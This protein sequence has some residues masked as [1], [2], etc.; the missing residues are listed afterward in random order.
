MGISLLFRRVFLL[1]RNPLSFLLVPWRLNF[2][3]F[4]RRNDLSGKQN[5]SAGGQNTSAGKRNTS[6]GRRNEPTGG[7]NKSAGKRNTSAGR[8][9]ESVGEQN[10]SAGRQNTSAGGRNEPAGGQNTSAGRRNEPAGR[11][12]RSAKAAAGS[13]SASAPETAKTAKK[14]TGRPCPGKG[15][16]PSLPASRDCFIRLCNTGSLL[17][18]SCATRIT[19]FSRFS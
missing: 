12:N 11:R 4:L 17:P 5:T 6:A 14:R 15:G 16:R 9:N 10:K 19:G 7:Q 8:R 2:L 18:N 13:G 3:F 1:L